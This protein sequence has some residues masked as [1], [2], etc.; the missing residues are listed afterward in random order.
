MQQASQA[1]KEIEPQLAL[2]QRKR[3]YDT[4]EARRLDV[5][6]AH[7]RHFKAV[8][9]ELV[10]EIASQKFASTAI[11]ESRLLQI[12]Y[13]ILRRNLQFHV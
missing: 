7:P 12:F 2:V 8:E 9:L 11:C 5:C 10:A 3:R 6:T 4:E 13:D 1:P